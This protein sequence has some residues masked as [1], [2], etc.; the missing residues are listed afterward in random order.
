[1]KSVSYG[2]RAVYDDAPAA[3]MSTIFAMFFNPWCTRQCTF[4]NDFSPDSLYA[5]MLFASRLDA[6]GVANKAS[7]SFL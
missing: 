4:Y 2:H 1:V 5:V 3:I 6:I 7:Q